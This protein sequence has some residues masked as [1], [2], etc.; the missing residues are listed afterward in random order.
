MAIIIGSFGHGRAAY[1]IHTRTVFFYT[2]LISAS[3]S[4]CFALYN[5]HWVLL[6]DFDSIDYKA[7]EETHFDQMRFFLDH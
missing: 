5:C 1:S 3:V 7:L 6:Q 2:S 4:S